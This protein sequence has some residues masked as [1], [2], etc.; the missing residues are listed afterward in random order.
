MKAPNGFT[1]LKEAIDK[2]IES[3]DAVLSPSTIRGYRIA[4]K[5]SFQGIMN[6]KLKSLSTE[7]LQEAVNEEAKRLI[8]KNSKKKI[9]P[10]TV[11]NR[12][13]L[14]TAVINQY[15]PR[16]NCTV[17][18]PQLENNIP[19]M[20]DPGEIMQA[21]KGDWLE[22]AVLLAM[23]LSFTMSEIRG[24]T[25]SKSLDDDYLVIREVKIK[26]GNQDVTKPQ[27][28][29]E[30]RNRMH[31]IPAYIKQLI[32]QVEGD[33][34]VPYSADSIYRHFTRVLKREGIPHI[35]FHGLRHLNASVMA[36]LQIPE[37]YA[38]ERGGWKTDKVMKK[39]Y[40]HTFSKERQKV[41]GIIDSYFNSLIP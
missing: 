29:V 35:S 22:L 20:P 13:G 21:F 3:S 5:N 32:D 9:S 33:I 14:I 11:K 23:W 39:V 17:R 36:M 30:T 12:Y 2:Y 6:M 28:K 19:Q 37:K 7:I 40:T 1:T 15:Y 4:Q 10:K 31:H 41:D 8:G 34:I 38:M 26:L 25:K 18:L 16:L 24:L 27:G